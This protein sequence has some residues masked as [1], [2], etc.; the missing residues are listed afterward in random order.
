LAEG[1]DEGSIHEIYLAAWAQ[2]MAQVCGEQVFT[3][4]AAEEPTRIH[5]NTVR[6]GYELPE[7]V[8]DTRVG[9]MRQAFVALLASTPA[10][11]TA[12]CKNAKVDPEMTR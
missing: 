5:R 11:A 7:F 4:A 9:R 10:E 1:I 2:S 12:F 3:G 6:A 8:F